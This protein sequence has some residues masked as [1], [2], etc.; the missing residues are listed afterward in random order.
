MAF[1]S[2]VTAATKAGL[3]EVSM[4]GSLIIARLLATYPA[5]YVCWRAAAS[6]PFIRLPPQL[7]LDLRLQ[8]EV[9]C[10]QYVPN[11][12]YVLCVKNKRRV[13]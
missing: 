12:G 3:G 13:S 8:K 11:C 5:G 7:P 2:L 10:S 9:A 4:G 1:S 6:P